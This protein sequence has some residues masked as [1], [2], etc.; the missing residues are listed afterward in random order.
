VIFILYG[1]ALL[2]F[3]AVAFFV[4]RFFILGRKRDNDEKEKSVQM[5]NLVEKQSQD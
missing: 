4:V 1:V 3:I 2:V 5:L